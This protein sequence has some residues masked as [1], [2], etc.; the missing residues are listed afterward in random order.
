MVESCSGITGSLS[1]LTWYD[2]P[3]VTEF[4]FNGQIVSGYWT[5]GSNSIVLADSSQLD[6][7]V[8][9]HEMLH[10]LIKASGHPRSEFL[11]KC[12][13]L[14]SCTPQCVTDGGPAPASNL[15]LPSLPADSL[16]VTVELAPKT[17]TINVDGGVFSVVVLAHN[18]KPYAV[19]IPQTG[20]ALAGFE[21]FSF[22]VRPEF[23]VGQR[24]AG[25]LSL[26]DPSVSTFAAGETKRQYFD[27]RIG[28][29]LR[30]RTVSP[31]VYR[32][33]GS[34]GSRSA[35]LTPVTVGTP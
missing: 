7:S 27:F 13:G 30:N 4:Q 2:V 32:V 16:V 15:V 20:A 24:I 11:E 23:S 25:G 5:R 26:S 8:V 35:I 9:R 14:V 33:T 6:G 18:P 19:T 3:G 28:T 31:G 12:A 1:K 29:I 22:Q 21:S 17:P 34:Y 10:S